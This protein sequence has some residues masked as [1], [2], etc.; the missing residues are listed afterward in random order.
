MDT[1]Q[2]VPRLGQ[3]KLLEIEYDQEVKD[4]GL[5]AKEYRDLLRVR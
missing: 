4:Y 5:Y 1:P 3:I 2:P